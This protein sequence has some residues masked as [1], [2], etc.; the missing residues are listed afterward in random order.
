[1][2]PHMVASFNRLAT[3]KVK[4]IKPL[5]F[6]I[7]SFYSLYVMFIQELHFVAAFPDANVETGGFASK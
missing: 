4:P 3:I 5:V 1:M 6:I 7:L 2:M